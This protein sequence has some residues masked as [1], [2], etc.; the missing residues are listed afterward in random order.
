MM[1]R[2]M[3]FLG[4]WGFGRRREVQ[5]LFFVLE[6]YLM[7][8]WVEE[9]ATWMLLLACRAG[10]LRAGLVLGI[11]SPRR[12]LDSCSRDSWTDWETSGPQKRL[13]T[14]DRAHCVC[15]TC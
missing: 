4:L 12:E 6:L 1:K 14:P 7:Y 3:W 8:R 15:S 13:G 10:L 9:I 2:R 11:E 5:G